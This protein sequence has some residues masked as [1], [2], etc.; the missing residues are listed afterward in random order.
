MEQ[1]TTDDLRAFE[2]RLVEVIHHM[3]PAAGRWRV[4]LLTT[5][6]S[7]VY[8]AYYCATDPATYEVRDEC[9]C[10]DAHIILQDHITDSLQRH[11]FFTVS[12][13]LLVILLC[14]GIHQKIMAPSITAA[15]FGPNLHASS[16]KAQIAPDP[17]RIQHELRR[18]WP[19]D[20]EAT[21]EHAIVNRPNRIAPFCAYRHRPVVQ[22]EI[23][24]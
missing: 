21:A 2:R 17:R 8:F 19:V 5:C 13:A 12:M 15:R 23:G 22:L 9:C 20:I 18:S 6:I 11:M 1:S 16:G 24:L 7:C 14:L 3:Q 10:F 4:L